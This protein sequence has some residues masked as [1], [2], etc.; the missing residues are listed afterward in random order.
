MNAMKRSIALLGLATLMVGCTNEPPLA[1]T[2]P[3]EVVVAQPVQE[4]IEDL[5][6]YTG[7]VE[8]RDAVEV[9]SRVRGHIVDV[10]FTEGE[11]VAEGTDLY[12]IDSDPFKADLQ[13]AKGQLTTWQARLQFAEERIGIYKPLADK[14]TVSREEYLSAL[15]AKGESLGGIETAKGKIREAEKNIEYCRIQARVAGRVGKALVAKGALVNVGGAETLLTT[16]V[17]VNPMYVEFNINETAHQNYL[18]ILNERDAK[19]K[20]TKEPKIPLELAVLGDTGYPH[21]GVV[22][23]IDNRID[24]GTSS[25]KIRGKFDN[26]KGPGG[27]RPLTAGMFARV[28]VSIVEPYQAI[29]VA[30]RAILTDQSAKYVL[31]VNKAK[32]NVVERVEVVVSNRL[33]ESGLRA[34]QGGLKGD[35]WIIVDGINRARPGV[36]VDPKEDKMPRRPVPGK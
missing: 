31:V 32:K 19:R 2:P 5:D 6:V 27:R 3:P 4:K 30:D 36:S 25:R 34:I 14:G 8:S 35:E 11:E 12:I 22:D 24:P 26:P 33:Q 1:Q 28:R 20:E 18:K 21:K 9:R 7:T 16:I 10:P 17:P 23:F 15:S 29:L 13:Q